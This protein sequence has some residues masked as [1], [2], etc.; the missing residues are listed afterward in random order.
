MNISHS[1][2]LKVGSVD[3]STNSSP[4]EVISGCWFFFFLS[5]RHFILKTL[6]VDRTSDFLQFTNEDTDVQGVWI[7]HHGQLPWFPSS[8]PLHSLHSSLSPSRSLFPEFSCLIT[9]ST[10]TN[11]SDLSEQEIKELQCTNSCLGITVTWKDFH[12]QLRS[13]V[14]K[15]TEECNIKMLSFSLPFCLPWNNSQPETHFR[16]T[17]LSLHPQNIIKG[18]GN[19]LGVFRVSWHIWKK[20]ALGVLWIFLSYSLELEGHLWNWC[21]YHPGANIKISV[22]VDRVMIVLLLSK[23]QLL[24]LHRVVCW[25]KWNE[26]QEKRK[27]ITKPIESWAPLEGICYR[28]I[29]Q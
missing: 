26:I 28:E 21:S 23:L 27:K 3:L 29:Y 4:Q 5:L 24:Y 18:Q 25:I 15:I 11:L 13:L 1:T 12:C 10:V 19:C 16:E 2:W 7:T 8:F 9:T 20:V 22:E 14:I 17:S 6:L